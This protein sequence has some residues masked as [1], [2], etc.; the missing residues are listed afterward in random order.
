[1]VRLLPRNEGK[2]GIIP[3]K[4]QPME[5]KNPKTAKTT[6]DLR[7]GGEIPGAEP[8]DRDNNVLRS[9]TIYFSKFP[10]FGWC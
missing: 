8:C 4:K 9:M 2:R 3:T 1:V 5:T 7:P 6:T 10:K